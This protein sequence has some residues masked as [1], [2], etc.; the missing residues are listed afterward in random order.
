MTLKTVLATS[1]VA[2]FALSTGANALT[3]SFGP[4]PDPGPTTLNSNFSFDPTTFAGITLQVGSSVTQFTADF[5]PGGLFV[6]FSDDV[7]S[8]T[9][10]YTF[11]GSE[12]GYF[13][14]VVGDGVGFD[15]TE[16]IG[17]SVSEAF[18]DLS[19]QYLP[20]GFSSVQAGTLDNDGGLGE[21]GLTLS[22]SE[23]KQLSSDTAA[24]IALFGDNTG[25]EDRDD[26][27]VGITITEI[28]RPGGPAVVPLPAPVFLLL[29]GLGGLA[30]LRRRRPA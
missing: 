16:T 22:F 19:D 13:N 10:E 7:I 18:A 8:A 14:S 6:D 23:I 27:M 24:V 25:D 12:A 5:A 4:T 20:F 2:L 9:V 15:E 26:F 21:D 3:L 30:L 11:L 29:G 1:A 28:T 17:F